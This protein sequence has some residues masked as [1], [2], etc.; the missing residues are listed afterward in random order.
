MSGGT[1]IARRHEEMVRGQAERLFPLLHAMMEEAGV[2]WRDLDALAVG[3]GPGN[4][5]GLRVAVAAARGL[6]LS[7]G[8]PAFGVDGFATR[9]EGTVGPALTCIAAPRGAVH[10]RRMGPGLDDAVET[11][12]PD[13]AREIARTESLVLI[14]EALGAPPAYPLAEAIGRAAHR[15]HAAGEVPARP[16]PFYVR[17]PDA[18]PSRDAAPTL[19][20]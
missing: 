20:P 1:V 18:A 13:Q 14:G 16:A 6:A 12:T 4:F 9:A 10:A 5:T 11:A 17:P 8:L 3:T 19:L 2:G 7:T 15:R